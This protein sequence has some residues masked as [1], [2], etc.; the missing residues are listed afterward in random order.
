MSAHKTKE[1]E[2]AASEALLESFE[3]E[4]DIPALEKT[5][6]T[7]W[8]Q[9]LLFFQQVEQ[10]KIH[11]QQFHARIPPPSNCLDLRQMAAERET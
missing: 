2:E 6:Q 11:G 9:T 1:E 7:L 3:K 10:L 4:L 5:L 8:Q